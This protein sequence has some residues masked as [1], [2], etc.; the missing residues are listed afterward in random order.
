VVTD[1]EWFHRLGWEVSVSEDEA[2]VYEAD[3]WPKANPG[4]RLYRV[5][6]GVR[7]EIAIA[8]AREFKERSIASRPSVSRL[9]QYPLTIISTRYGGGYEGGLWAA[10]PLRPEEIPLEATGDDIECQDWWEDPPVAVGLGAT[11][12]R[13]VAA[14]DDVIDQCL[15]PPGRRHEVPTP[16]AGYLCS[17]CQQF[18]HHEE[19]AHGNQQRGAS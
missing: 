14:L 4:L 15:H 3:I 17:Y 13:A 12:D 18:R 11:P 16:P 7:P 9:G 10:F 19:P 2:G 6:R 1:E 5:T 8:H